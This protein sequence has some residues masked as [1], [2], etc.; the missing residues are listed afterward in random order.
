MEDEIESLDE[1]ANSKKFF[2]MLVHNEECGLG[3]FYYAPQDLGGGDAGG[4]DLNARWAARVDQRT[5]LKEGYTHREV[6]F[7]K[8]FQLY[9][10]DDFIELFYSEIFGNHPIYKSPRH[11]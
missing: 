9:M 8:E 3:P 6:E 5:V 4:G 11:F 10:L 2:A 7:E 1:S